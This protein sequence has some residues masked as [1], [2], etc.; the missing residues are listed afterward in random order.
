MRAGEP[1]RIDNLRTLRN[2]N[3]DMAFSTSF[4]TLTTGAFLVGGGKSKGS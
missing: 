1:S 4:L 2:A 3:L